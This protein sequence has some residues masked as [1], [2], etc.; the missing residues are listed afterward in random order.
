[1]P[2]DES[3]LEKLVGQVTAANTHQEIDF[4]EPVGN[5]FSAKA[6]VSLGPQRS[7]PTK[8]GRNHPPLPEDEC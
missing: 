6:N 1:M 5:E 3:K 4:G 7:A 8:A 2:K